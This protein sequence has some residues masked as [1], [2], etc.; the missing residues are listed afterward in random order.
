M[1]LAFNQVV[2]QTHRVVDFISLDHPYDFLLVVHL[3]TALNLLLHHLRFLTVIRDFGQEHVQPL[4]ITRTFEQFDQL[5]RAYF[6]ELSHCGTSHD[7][8]VHLR[9]VDGQLFHDRQFVRIGQF[10]HLLDDEVLRDQLRVQDDAL[11]VCDAGLVLQSTRHQPLALAQF[12]DVV[13]VEVVE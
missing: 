3:Q 13:F 11:D 2:T 6:L 10:G 7:L 4:E 8:V 12:G 9:V 1:Q 5:D